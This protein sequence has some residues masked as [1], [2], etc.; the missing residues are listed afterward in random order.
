MSG[1]S[2]AA[3]T[4]TGSRRRGISWAPHFCSGS[5]ANR[6]GS[7][8]LVAAAATMRQSARLQGTRR[9]PIG[10]ASSAA[11]TRCAPGEIRAGALDGGR[12]RSIS[13]RTSRMWD[14]AHLIRP[15]RRVH[16]QGK[17]D[18]PTAGRRVAWHPL[19][20]VEWWADGANRADGPSVGRTFATVDAARQHTGPEGHW[21]LAA[22]LCDRPGGASAAP[23]PADYRG[24]RHLRGPAVAGLRTFV[25]LSAFLVYE[26]TN[27]LLVGLTVLAFVLIRRRSRR[28]FGSTS[29]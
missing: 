28:R 24:D 4:K 15:I 18:C 21:R 9:L 19:I 23:A 10:P 5:A 3:F 2:D 29:R 14:R 7:A 26:A 6:S 22:D 27:W 8:D 1:R 12:L 16:A 20:R 25:P 11:G 17:G 13:T